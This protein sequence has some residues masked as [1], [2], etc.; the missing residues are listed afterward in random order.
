MQYIKYLVLQGLE[1]TPHG[2]E[3]FEE[4][5]EMAS[6]RSGRCGISRLPLVVAKRLEQLRYFFLASLLHP[7]PQECYFWYF[8]RQRQQ[9]AVVQFAFLLVELEFSA[10]LLKR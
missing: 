5:A 2:I 3:P 6:A 8:R 4:I 9:E 1:A 10:E 7:L